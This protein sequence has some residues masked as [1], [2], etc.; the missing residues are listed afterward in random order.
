MIC[1]VM[2]CAFK[3]TRLDHHLISVHRMKKGDIAYTHFLAKASIDAKDLKRR[4]AQAVRP[5][6]PP[7]V[8]TLVP[9]HLSS[10]MMVF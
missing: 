2:G 7:K 6:I 5:T 1:P 10:E 4:T 8:S 3:G 9:Q